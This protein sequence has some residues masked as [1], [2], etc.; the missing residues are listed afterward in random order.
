MR[1][2]HYRRHFSIVKRLAAL[3]F[4]DEI[5]KRELWGIIPKY[6]TALYPTP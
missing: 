3:H 4:F 6:I 5:E 2:F 1:P